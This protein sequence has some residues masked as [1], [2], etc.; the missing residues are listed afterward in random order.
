MVDGVDSQLALFIFSIRATR[1]KTNQLLYTLLAARVISF[2]DC[3]TVR[4]VE[5]IVTLQRL[6]AR[7]QVRKDHDSEFLLRILN[8]LVKSVSS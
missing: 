4:S 6:S 2:S 3:R 5:T 1:A 8:G 7:L